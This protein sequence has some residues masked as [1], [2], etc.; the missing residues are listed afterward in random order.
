MK[1]DLLA[2]APHPDDVELTCGGT[3]L[4]MADEGYSTGILDLTQGETGTRGT[5]QIRA[6]EADRAAQFLRVKIRRNAGLPDAH[7]RV[8]D[9]YKAAIAE[10]IRE[11]RP[12]TVI[13]PYWEGR[14]PDHYTAATLGFEAC[15]I[16]GLKNYPL[17]GEVFRPFKIIYAAAYST[18][19]PT[20][21]VDITRQYDR[22]RRAILAY[23]S[24][25][26]PPKGAPRSKVFLPLDELEDHM[27]LMARH[28]GRLAGVKYAEGFVVKEVMQVDDV[29]NLPVRSV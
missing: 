18:V 9:E 11:L 19:A 23:S 22:R 15:F 24:Q 10:I 20:F 16:A 28:Y 27:S 12:R 6:R 25:F 5:P 2:I 7:L 1:L 21:V 4:K 3:L 26:T 14:H 17:A 29:V 13:L 8:C